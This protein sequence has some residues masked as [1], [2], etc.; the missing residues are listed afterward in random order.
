ML[1]F[2][3]QQFGDPER[4][5]A[6]RGPDWVTLAAAYGIEPEKVKGP[7]EPLRAALERAA[8]GGRPRLLHLEAE[9]TPPR[10]TSPRWN[11]PA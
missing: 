9:L 3:Q 8:D 6:L 7:G 2:D 11:D 1:R 10:T 4:G 5:V